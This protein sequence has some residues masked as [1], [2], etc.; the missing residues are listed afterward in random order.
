[1]HV[2]I[3]RMLINEQQADVE[4]RNSGHYKHTF[5]THWLDLDSLSLCRV[6]L[7]SDKVYLIQIKTLI[8]TFAGG[9]LSQYL[10]RFDHSNDMVFGF[11]W[12][13]QKPTQP[14]T[15][16][17]NKQTMPNATT[18]WQVHSVWLPSAQPMAMADGMALTL[19]LH[20]QTLGPSQLFTLCLHSDSS[21]TKKPNPP[22]TDNRQPMTIDKRLFQAGPSLLTIHSSTRKIN[23]YSASSISNSVQKGIKRGPKSSFPPHRI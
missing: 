12:L 19:A 15:T 23:S 10:G 9:P 7:H 8:L 14:L 17:H 21:H 4:E 22:T 2:C 6:P 1:M 18:A 5:T 13:P 20:W 3:S 11:D 16:N